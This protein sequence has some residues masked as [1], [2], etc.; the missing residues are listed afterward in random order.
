MGFPDFRAK[1]SQ[2]ASCPC[3]GCSCAKDF[4]PSS[5]S[6]VLWAYA[7][8]GYYDRVMCN[9]LGRRAA[10][11]LKHMP[12]HE[13]TQ[14]CWSLATLRHHEPLLTLRLAR[15]LADRAASA[16]TASPKS[17]LAPSDNSHSHSRGAAGLA[18]AG[19]AAM[20]PHD[21][22]SPSPPQAVTLLWSLAQMPLTAP[23]AAARVEGSGLGPAASLAHTQAASL[24]C[25]VLL[26][27]GAVEF[28][29]MRDCV[30]A[31]W[32][33]VVLGVLPAEKGDS[34]SMRDS[35]RGLAAKL[36][37]QLRSC[38][39]QE[40]SEEQLGVL[41]TAVQVVG[42]WWQVQRSLAES[43]GL[44]WQGHEGRGR[45]EQGGL[46]H[47]EP[48]L[49]QDLLDTGNGMSAAHHQQQQQHCI[50]EQQQ[51]QQQQQRDHP[52]Q[53][54]QYA[55]QDPASGLKE[56]A[57]GIID[58]SHMPPL[59]FL[60]SG[61]PCRDPH[62]QLSV[63]RDGGAEQQVAQ[64]LPEPLREAAQAA[65][66]RSA[67]ACVRENGKPSLWEH[68]A[69]RVAEALGLEPVPDA[70]ALSAVESCEWQS[71]GGSGSSKPML[72]AHQL[73]GKGLTAFADAQGLLVALL[74][75][76][77]AHH[78]RS[79]P[80]LPLGSTHLARHSLQCAGWAVVTLPWYEWATL[81]SFEDQIAYLA[82]KCI[83]ADVR[84]P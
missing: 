25:R 71:L 21:L 22:V 73:A 43:E 74:C 80:F 54:Q 24:L 61:P 68:E 32:G 65:V 37:L 82:G 16:A 3:K 41:H 23:P 78:T 83:E 34:L 62:T 58:V 51:Q 31:L 10:L 9:T 46:Q 53:E 60:R 38:P 50:H 59:A 55:T 66:L 1:G 19:A 44:Q 15:V 52:Q 39:P 64:C 4:T 45:F 42:G 30:R 26:A 69:Y 20:H 8:S 79:M 48:N 35:C 13:V 18:G 49:E 12:M 72:Q 57:R 77:P 6:T 27:P 76:G 2:H 11:S 81:Q 33:A 84:I 47:V 63:Q 75:E 67:A 29:S 40:L 70:T 7:A 5:L 17:T 36:L 56:D 14:V 28:L